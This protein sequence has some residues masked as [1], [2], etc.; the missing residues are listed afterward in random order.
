VINQF[1]FVHIVYFLGGSRIICLKNA[2]PFINLQGFQL[3]ANK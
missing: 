1:S 2:K 3:S